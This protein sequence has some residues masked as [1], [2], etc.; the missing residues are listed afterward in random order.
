MY[1]HIYIYI[2]I[3]TYIH[4]YIYIVY[5]MK[6]YCKTHRKSKY[7][8]VYGYI[9]DILRY[10]KF[11]ESGSDRKISP[12]S[13]STV[14]KRLISCYSY[15]ELIGL[16]TA[17]FSMQKV[18]RPCQIDMLV[19]SQGFHH[20]FG[21]LLSLRKSHPFRI[22]PTDPFYLPISGFPNHFHRQQGLI[23]DGLFS[24]HSGTSWNLHSSQPR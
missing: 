7:L 17:S 8:L 10:S 12:D 11:K 24:G 14:L 3:Y 1:I 13:K 16:P 9:Y 19:L 2:H 20:W 21:K 15:T 22:L 23:P 6:W 5:R 18:K 4:I